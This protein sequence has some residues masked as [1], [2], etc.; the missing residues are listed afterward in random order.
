MSDGRERLEQG[1]RHY[2]GEYSIYNSLFRMGMHQL[3]DSDFPESGVM[4]WLIIHLIFKI[5][6]PLQ[7]KLAGNTVNLTSTIPGS[8]WVAITTSDH[9]SHSAD[10]W[11]HIWA[12]RQKGPLNP[13]DTRPQTAF[14]RI[15]VVAGMICFWQT[16]G[17]Y[18][19]VSRKRPFG[20]SCLPDNQILFWVQYSRRCFPPI[21]AATEGTLY[22]F[23]AGW[24]IC[25]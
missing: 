16:S 14:W 10:S 13:V 1:L 12:D 24:T 8:W 3:R 17:L 18:P 4:H 9:I 5:V 6:L 15:S 7:K 22:G 20:Q 19:W 25:F 23:P 2:I 21:H 11:W